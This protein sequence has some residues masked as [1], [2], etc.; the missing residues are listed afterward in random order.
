MPAPY[1]HLF[2]DLDHTLWDFERSALLTF[3][4]MHT[5]FDL[6][7]PFELYYSY[8]QDVNVALWDLYKQNKIEKEVLAIERFTRTLKHFGID[9]AA[10]L[11]A[12]MATYYRY[13]SPRKVS[14]FE[15]CHELLSYLHGRYEMHIITNG[16]EEIQHVKLDRGGLG[17][18]FKHIITSEQVGFK[19]PDSRI[20]GFAMEQS[21]ADPAESLMI[22][23]DLASD[24]DG[25]RSVGMDQALVHC[26]QCH[27]C[28][29][30]YCFPDLLSLKRLL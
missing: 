22:G 12:E 19:K 29:A 16:F 30:T 8:Y 23:D 7:I 2:F 21:G 3:Q 14:L 1:K 27:P 15:G 11:A 9:D 5:V 20:F 18:Y 6:N 13:H 25:A 10:I 26:K 24:I 4:E 17:R 28:S